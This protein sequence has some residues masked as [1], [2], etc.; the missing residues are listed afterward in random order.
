MF[1]IKKFFIFCVSAILISPSIT[2]GQKNI[3]LV[4]STK[5]ASNKTE[6]QHAFKF[7]ESQK[8]YQARLISFRDF[9]NIEYSAG[10]TVI[11]L[12]QQNPESISNTQDFKRIKNTLST[13]IN[14]GG[15]VLLTGSSAKWLNTLNLESQSI[16]HRNREVKDNGYGRKAGLHGINHHPVFKGL[17][18]GAYLI[19]PPKDMVVDQYGFFGDNTPGQGKTIAVDWAYIFLNEGEKIMMEYKNAKVMAIGSFIHFAMPNEHKK[20]LE[21]FIKNTLDYIFQGKPSPPENYWSYEPVS[22][23]EK[24]FSFPKLFYKKPGILAYMKPALSLERR[25][26]T[27]QYCETSGER[28]LLMGK[29]K[30]GIDEI[31]AHP[32][33]GLRDYEVGIR[34][35]YSKR[36]YWLN[37]QTPHFINMPEGFKRIYKFNRAYLTE[38]VVAGKNTPQALI[39]YDY[40]GVY[41]AEVYIR[42]SNNFRIMWPYSS[43]A[44]GDISYGILPDNQTIVMQEEKFDSKSI[45]GVNKPTE[46]IICGHFEDFEITDSTITGKPTKKHQLHGLFHLSLKM[47]DQFDVLFTAG[48]EDENE[49][50]VQYVNLAKNPYTLYKSAN[51]FYH[52]F[53]ENKTQ[54]ISPDQKFNEAWQWTLL[55]TDKFYVHT[56]GIGKS[57]MAGFATTDW[58]WDGKHDIN[59]RPGYAWYFGRDAQWS[60][61]ALLGYGDYEKV[62][63]VLNTFQVFQDLTGKIYHELSSSGFVH[64]DASD[65]TPLYVVLAGKYLQYSGDTA[66]IRKSLPYIIKAMDYCYSTDSDGDLLIE[67]TNVG[68]GWVEGGHLY[69]AK[70]SIYLASCWA[71]ALKQAAFIMKTLEIENLEKKYQADYKKVIII[72]N[73]NFYD[74]KQDFFSFGKWPDDSFN[75]V[76]TIMPTIPMCFE[77]L[78]N[79]KVS[80]M[81]KKWGSADFSSDWGTRIIGKD[82]PKYNARGYHTGSVWPLYTG[83]TSMAEYAYGNSRQGFQHVLNNLLIYD[84][85]ALGYIEEVLN[86]ETYKPGGVCRHQCW[87]HTMAIQPVLDGLLGYKPN[88]INGSIQFSPAFPPSW[89][90][91][92]VKNLSFGSQKQFD[93]HYSKT[94][95]TISLVIERKFEDNIS[96]HFVFKDFHVPEYSLNGVPLIASRNQHNE[97]LLSFQ[98][99]SKRD[100][101]SIRLP[102]EYIQFEVISDPVKPYNNNKN[103]KI[104]EIKRYSEKI[105]LE[106]QGFPNTTGKFMLF[107]TKNITIESVENAQLISNKDNQCQ[108]E[109]HFNESEKNKDATQKTVSILF[110]Q[111]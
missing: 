22:I 30:G 107:S 7:L 76:E 109:V 88:A 40:K 51:L 69:G 29:E 59:G 62:K 94:G 95:N 45:I 9:L 41:P 100:S 13:H 39:H 98:S 60:S 43:K 103:I 1:K 18:G 104:S 61:F 5:D 19:R 81:L 55:N 93:L 36:I 73:Q 14:N 65:A 54:I 108:F 20:H 26:A 99:N 25:Y 31:W 106:V 11:W 74:E 80:N 8:E 6:I 12:H 32:F 64:Y 92:T 35:S 97:T 110:S 10:E 15:P 16:E 111:H 89:N 68:H 105:D 66:F 33:M 38:T 27:E 50:A 44:M 34:F 87:S 47:H 23:Q 21:I 53:L 102:D 77:Q 78:E 71:E 17:N 96:Y 86:G 49:L 101:L 2:C 28:L 67:N 57:L 56:P 42:F 24:D 37:E 91:A 90:Y 4:F 58:G 79:Q 82:H 63:N 85:F 3:F 70:T 52:D 48:N 46:H 75:T 84:D 83:W 72:L